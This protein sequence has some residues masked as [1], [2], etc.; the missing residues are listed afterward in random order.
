MDTFLTALD[1]AVE[2]LGQELDRPGRTPE[3]YKANPVQWAQERAGRTLWSKQREG[4]EAVR[5]N[6]RVLIQS[7]HSTGKTNNCA[8]IACWWIDVHPPGDAFV[9][10]TAPTGTQV[11][12][13][14]WREIGR[15][16]RRAGLA[17]RVN[18]TE[19]YL[20]NELVAF[21]RKSSDHDDD[22]FQGIHALNVLVIIDEACH[23]DQTDV[24]TEFGWRRFADL[25]GTERLLTMDPETG[26]AQHLRPARLIAKHYTGP[27]MQ[28]E[29]SGTNFC[30]TP[31]HEMLLN[32]YR[33]NSTR[34][35]RKESA[36]KLWSRS[37]SMFGRMNIQKHINW[38]TPDLESIVVPGEVHKFPTYEREIPEI[39]FQA[40]S[41]FKFLG[42]YMSD[43]SLGAVRNGVPHS[44]VITQ[45]E[46]PKREE[47]AA[48][49]LALGFPVTRSGNCLIIG[50]TQLAKYLMQL[51]GRYKV[52]R[53]VP[54]QLRDASARQIS[55]FL[56]SY[57]QG[58]G[59]RKRN[60]QII[61]TYSRAMADGLQEL[62]LKTGVPSVVHG[63]AAFDRTLADGRVIH[64]QLDGWV[65]TRPDTTSMSRLRP[66]H[67]RAVDYDGMVYCATLPRH[68]LLFTRRGGYTMWSGN[69]GI[70]PTIWT[71]AESIASNKYSKILAVGNPDDPDSEFARK[72]ASPIWHKIKIGYKDTPNFTGED[73]PELLLD[74]LISREWVDERKTEWGEESALFQ[75]KCN[76]EF[77]DK[78]MDSMSVIPYGMASRCRIVESDPS[79]DH[80]SVV[81]SHAGV[82]VGAGGD[83][84]VVYWRVGNKAVQ[85]LEFKDSDPMATVGRIAL[86]LREWGVRKVKIDVGGIGW[87]VYGRLRELSMAHGAGHIDA[88]HEANVVGVNFGSRSAFPKRF[89]NKRAEMWWAGREMSRTRAWDL[90]T[91]DDN[92]VSQLT[93]PRY[94]IM[95]S[96]GKVQV[97][98]KSEVIKRLGRSPDLADALLLAFYDGPSSLHTDQA[99]DQ[100]D[101]SALQVFGR[102]TLRGGSREGGAANPFNQIRHL[103]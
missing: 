67:R 20:D 71:A 58:D 66:E 15:L 27:M 46:G 91:L 57:V 50:S 70:V 94:K 38:Q 16:H 1:G 31:D 82:D 88:Q 6:R 25:D 99:N 4:I 78:G 87:G 41:W 13:L 69:C 42:W 56:D 81:V 32:E 83:S 39:V 47:A 74:S 95:D 96:G 19:W 63:R 24:M 45:K 18:L 60:G 48:A 33:P 34:V 90:S 77:P 17:G 5:D 12:A 65:V 3:F 52:Q 43:G 10:T 64:G 86:Q 26:V 51:C 85:Y 11:K 73:V 100:L 55:M 59:Y 30:V 80:P 103:L 75:S 22:A 79:A 98:A 93:A 97:E 61:Y 40:D 29:T 62:I 76:G 7:C 102:E 84:T 68:H 89:A 53:F 28:Y 54:Q 37:G 101:I 2:G 9:I 44:V 8:T 36:E 14:L 49:M 72:A 35:W 21:G 92:V 23:D